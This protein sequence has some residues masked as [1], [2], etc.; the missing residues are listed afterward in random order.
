METEADGM[1][2][3]MIVDDER[4]I[5]Q[6][7][8]TVIPWSDM[9]FQVVGEASG[10]KAAKALALE[11]KPDVLLTDI[12]MADGTGLEL[13]EALQRD[14]PALKTV[15]ISGYNDFNYAV[16]A[17]KLRVE[18]YILKP[19]DPEEIHR[20]F[21]KIARDLDEERRSQVK[22]SST[23][24]AYTEYEM[25]H[26]LYNDLL[27][28]DFSAR[29]LHGQGQY[30]LLLLRDM[31]YQYDWSGG[32]D[33]KPS[34]GDPIPLGEALRGCYHI[35]TE[36]LMLV[37][38][39]AG[40]D[41]KD[42]AEGL[43]RAL[44]KDAAHYRIAVGDTVPELT[45]GV[46]AYISLSS[47]LY[48][49]GQEQIVCQNHG[50]QRLLNENLTSLR[51]KL[52]E[53][54]ENGAPIEDTLAQIRRDLHLRKRDPRG[55]YLHVLQ[56]VTR[57][58]QIGG[59]Q[60]SGLLREPARGQMEEAEQQALEAAFTGDIQELARRVREQG[61]SMAEILARKAI[62]EIE[63]SYGD[64]DVSLARL[65]E[66]LRVSYGYL[67]TVF[68]RQI[69][70]GFAAYLAEVRM[71]KAKSLLL[72]REL[73]VYEVAGMVGYRNARYFSDAFKKVTGL[74]PGEYVARMKGE[75]P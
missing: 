39:P 60:P 11:C 57:Y 55:A 2:K 66:K 68:S 12:R 26:R 31:D 51:K 3:L 67:S 52:I 42:F 50:R 20:V 16:K 21:T 63:L 47:L 34:L 30:H 36:G 38:L 23:H 5:R 9:G 56:E 13:I 18:D 10:V 54:L 45:G 71:E 14:M 27:E 62:T 41:A 58:F 40:R 32:K 4:L 33:E 46:G 43:M 53:Q 59:W 65:A 19:I 49:Q 17:L 75:G 64:S 1:Y 69:G 35:R 44:G 61:G 25:I 15:T 73:K 70:K 8:M 37:I 6:G 48:A 72:R 28:E 7:L 74:S 22:R 29:Y 24:Y